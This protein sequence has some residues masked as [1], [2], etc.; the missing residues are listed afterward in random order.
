[1][2]CF[3]QCWVGYFF[4]SNLAISTVRKEFNSYQALRKISSSGK[5]FVTFPQ[6]KYGSDRY[7]NIPVS[8]VFYISL[9]VLSFCLDV[10]KSGVFSQTKAGDNRSQIEKSLSKGGSII[11]Q[12]WWQ[13]SYF[14]WKERICFVFYEFRVKST[15]LGGD[16][17]PLF[18]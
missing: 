4:K 1:M 9:Q 12:R 15:N 16:Y 3:F 5:H 7:R 17:L 11:F 14:P 18:L 10:I 6:T 8:F 2:L 13:F